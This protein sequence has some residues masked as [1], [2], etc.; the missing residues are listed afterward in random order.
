MKIDVRL[1]VPRDAQLLSSLLSPQSFIASHL[2]ASITQIPLVHW[3]S[4]AEQPLTK[5]CKH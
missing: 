2:A 4:L 3:N 5:S 1:R